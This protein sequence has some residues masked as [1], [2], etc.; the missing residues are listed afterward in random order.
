MANKILVDI[1][2]TAITGNGTTVSDP[3]ALGPNE[4]A[5]IASL[6]IT[7]RTDGTAT[8]TVQTSISAD[9]PW[10]T[11]FAATGASANGLTFDFPTITEAPAGLLFARLSLAATSVTTGFTAQCLLMAVEDKS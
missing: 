9:G 10:V 7:N 5:Y 11:W 6:N 1:P 4:R 8:L 3:V 2:T